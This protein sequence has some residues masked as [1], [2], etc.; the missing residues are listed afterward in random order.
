MEK[1]CKKIA[2]QKRA[3]A[4]SSFSFLTRTKVTDVNESFMVTIVNFYMAVK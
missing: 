4:E 3:C 2:L 1:R